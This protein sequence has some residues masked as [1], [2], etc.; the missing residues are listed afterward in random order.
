MTAVAEAGLSSLVNFLESGGTV[1]LYNG[2]AKKAARMKIVLSHV[3]GGPESLTFEEVSDPAFGPDEVRVAVSACGI[4]Y[5][6]A[7]LIRDLYQVKPCRPFAPGSEIAGVVEAIG[8]EVSGFLPGDRVIGRTGWGGLA[9]KVVLPCTRLTRIP[10]AMPM[11]VAATFLFTFSTSYYALVDRGR[12]KAGETL[13][14]LGAAGGVGTSACAIGRALGLRVLAAVS[15]ADKLAFALR[16]GADD[17]IVYP[18]DMKPSE[19]RGLADALRT[20]GG[21][22]G[23]DLVY[24]GV[25][26]AYSEAALR[27]LNA[28][29][30]HLVVGFPAGIPKIPLNL[31]LLKSCSIVGVN[32]RTLT[33]DDPAR[34]EEN[35]QALMDLYA[36]GKISPVV[37]QR[38][39]FERARDAIALLEQR[40]ATGKI[41]VTLAAAR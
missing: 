15:S 6:D 11:E 21:P 40:G 9:E 33:M 1:R 37:S 41:V 3:A 27:T 19:I 36:Q 39:P 8:A 34:S 20:A 31:P 5:P 2:G 13:L 4:N 38:F 14:V 29:G 35:T 12:A 23:I 17:G 18:A 28:G 25:G 22:R 7:L 10:D 26:G 32:W 30:R 24:D 16:N